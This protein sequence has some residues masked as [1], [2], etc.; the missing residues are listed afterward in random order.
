MVHF[1]R[2]LFSW[3]PTSFTTKCHNNDDNDKQK[4]SPFRL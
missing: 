4:E 3:L 1:I 2:L